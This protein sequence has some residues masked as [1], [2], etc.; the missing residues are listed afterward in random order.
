LRLMVF[1]QG[2]SNKNPFFLI[3]LQGATTISISSRALELESGTC[4]S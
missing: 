2:S 4:P 1:I 3:V